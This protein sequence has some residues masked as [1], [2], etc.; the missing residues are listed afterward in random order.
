M[1][2]DLSTHDTKRRYEGEYGFSTHEG[3]DSVKF[4]GIW[5]YEGSLDPARP[6]SLLILDLKTTCPITKVENSIF[7]LGTTQLKFFVFKGAARAQREELWL[8]QVITGVVDATTATPM[9]AAAAVL[10]NSSRLQFTQ[11]LPSYMGHPRFGFI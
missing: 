11:S 1:S 10:C 7:P 6:I 4:S 3:R 8:S 2:L 9:E 5:D